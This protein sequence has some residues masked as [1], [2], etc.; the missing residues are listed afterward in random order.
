M[1]IIFCSVLRQIL[2][3]KEKHRTLLKKCIVQESSNKADA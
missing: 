2:E 1:Y 3:E